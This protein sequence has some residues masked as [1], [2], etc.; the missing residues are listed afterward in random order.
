MEMKKVFLAVIALLINISF[1]HSQDSGPLSEMYLTGKWK[2]ECTAEVMDR[3][4][5][6]MCE[7]CP[8]TVDTASKSSGRVSDFELNFLT[9]SLVIN[10][11]GN[12]VTVPYTRDKDNHSFAFNLSEKQYS[13]RVFLY[14]R[15]RILEDS[16]GS[17]IV[18]TRVN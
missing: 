7:L 1:A 4:G 3:S 5:L 18:L 9:D 16:Q 15:Q 2:A 6:R 14:N 8:F 13:F 17:L 10:R 12:E 11:N